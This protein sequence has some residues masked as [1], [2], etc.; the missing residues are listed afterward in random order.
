M[1]KLISYFF[2]NFQN[3]PYHSNEKKVKTLTPTNTEK[4][5]VIKS[6]PKPNQIAIDTKKLIPVN[7][8]KIVNNVILSNYEQ[9]YIAMKRSNA[10]TPIP[11]AK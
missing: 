6:F 7:I 5:V 1:Y 9:K 3:L 11:I 10:I 4:I 2:N 8:Q